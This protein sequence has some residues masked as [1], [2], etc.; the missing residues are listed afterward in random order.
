[1][2]QN[3]L[4][5]LLFNVSS[6]KN[7]AVRN[8]SESSFLGFTMYNTPNEVWLSFLLHATPLATLSKQLTTN[9]VVYIN[10]WIKNTEYNIIYIRI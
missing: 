3:F 9:Y 6:S 7:G 4:S 5:P 8:L 1:M 10:I 2:P